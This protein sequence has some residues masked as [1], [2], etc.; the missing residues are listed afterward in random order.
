MFLF[1]TKD[2]KST[3]VLKK[4]GPRQITEVKKTFR[5]K[6]L[7]LSIAIPIHLII[8]ENHQN[9]TVRSFFKHLT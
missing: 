4:D 3:K 1:P 9:L 5:Y 6:L 7:G 2:N 8:D